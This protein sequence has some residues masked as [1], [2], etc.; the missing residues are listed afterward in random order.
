[1]LS[2]GTVAV[3]AAPLFTS[4]AKTTGVVSHAVDAVDAAA[5]ANHLEERWVD[6]KLLY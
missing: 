1:M 3:K 2:V 5:C 4:V 6:G